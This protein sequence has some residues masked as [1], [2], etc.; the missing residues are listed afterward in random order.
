MIEPIF[1][2]KDITKYDNYRGISLLCHSEKIFASVSLQIIKARTEEIL[3]EA[4][5]GFRNGRSTIDQLYTLSSIAILSYPA[6]SYSVSR[7]VS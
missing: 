7:A 4:Q 6:I 5:A 3:S 2:K 1:K